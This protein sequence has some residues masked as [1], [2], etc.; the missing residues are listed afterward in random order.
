MKLRIFLVVFILAAAV[1]ARENRDFDFGWRFSKGNFAAAMMPGFDDSAWRTVNLPHDW[2]IEGPFSGEYGSGNGYAPGGVGWYR[3][4]FKLEAIHKDKLVAIEFDGVY[5]NSEVWIN[6]HLL[7][8]RPY[9]Y[10]SFQYDLT[11][12]LKFG[13]DENVIAVRVDHSKFADSRWYTGSGIYRHVRLRVTNKLRTAPWGTCV[14]TPEVKDDSATVRIETTIKNSSDEMKEFTLQSDIIAADGKIIAADV[15]DQKLAANS[16]QVIVRQI[17]IKNPQLWLI[18]NPV[19]YKL[20]SRIKQDETLMDEVFTTFGIRTIAFDPNKGFFLNGKNIKLKGV[21]L[22][23]DAG[24]LGAAVPDKVLERRLLLM[25]ELGANAIRTSHNPPAQEL[26]DICDRLGLLVKDE[27]FDEFTPPKNKWVTGWN[28]GVPSRFG[29]GEVFTLWSVIDI[30]EMVM[31]DRNHPCIIMWSIGNEIDYANDPFSHP[32]L[33]DQYRPEHPPAENLVKYAEPLITAV[34]EL[35]KTRPVTAALANIKMS[36]AVGLAQKLDVVGYNYQEQF[37]E[38]DHKNYPERFI[39]GSENGDQYNAWAVVR[40]NDYVAGQFLWTG[41]DYLGEAGRWPNTANS[42]GLLDLCGFKKPLAWFRQS[43]W[44]D[45]P[46]VYIFVSGGRGSRRGM[47]GAEHW[48]WPENSSV[49]VLC[50]TNCPEVSLIL[51]DKPIG[52]QQYSQAR[53]GMLRW[54]VPYEPGLLKATGNRDGKAVCEYVLQTAGPAS[55]IELLSDVTR[56][57]ADGKDIAHI[58][59]GIV[60]DK[61]V[62]VPDA[63][64]EVS[65]ELDGP[66]NII[67]IGNGN[68]NS[69]DDYKDNKHKAYNGRGLAILQAGP[70]SGKISIKAGAEGLKQ[71]TLEIEVVQ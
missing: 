46:M 25:K 56:I 66:G 47:R 52:T 62:I 58:E 1:S 13:S 41:I 26:L 60:D 44:S 11:R 3:K 42:T 39:F 65:F 70:D 38:A 4:H 12:H 43:L 28:N 64:H 61:G 51:N 69:I 55:Q 29:Y 7:G 20:R 68:I 63:E 5:N 8:E 6:G 40:D 54:N 2:S 71:S 10:I 37:Y 49:T 17:E 45:E 32:V 36:N 34:K 53:D 18:D 27:A 48:N 59:F 15:T 21:C 23:H 19:L 57:H 14:T 9:G 35:D 30:R 67:G 22:H 24:C 16:G 31:R 50:Y 33:G